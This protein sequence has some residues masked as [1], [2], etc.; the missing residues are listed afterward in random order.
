MVELKNNELIFNFPQVHPHASCRLDF[1]KTLRIPDDNREYEL[2]PGLGSFAM[3]HTDDHVSK[4]P[5]DWSEHGG[6]FLP[7]YQSEALWINFSG[8]AGPYGR[9]Y[10][11]AVKIA[12]GKINAVTGESWSDKLVKNPQDYLV[13][14]DQP[15]LDGY[16]V[17]KGLIRQFVAMPLGKGYTAEEQLTGE[18]T[19]GGLQVIVYPMKRERYEAMQKENR[20]MFSGDVCYSM[21][22]VSEALPMGLAP[23]GLMRQKIYEDE[24]GFDVWDQQHSSRCFIHILNSSQ[25][26]TITGRPVPGKSPS[27]TDYTQAGLPWFEYYNDKLNA[28]SGPEK[29]SGLDSVAA[30][31][32]KLGEEPLDQNDPVYPQNIQKLS[33]AKNQVTDGKW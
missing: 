23:G 24:Y 33:S 10:P 14:P 26:E 27:A 2:P 21:N 28:I 31:G 15:W 29:L 7:M 25:W 3:E 1:Q 32:I 17:K 22:M 18:A 11:F 6:V 5:K 30:K 20:K 4:I 12:T 13:V 9:D 16:C 19:H 8:A